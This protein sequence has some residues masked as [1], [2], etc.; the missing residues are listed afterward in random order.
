LSERRQ[1]VAAESTAEA[2][3][4]GKPYVLD[5]KRFL[6]EEVDIHIAKNALDF[7]T[8]PTLMIVIAE[9]CDRRNGAVLQLGREIMR[10]VGQ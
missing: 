5:D 10:L 1:H 7:F 8:L 6:T 2:F 9:D 3:D 4:S